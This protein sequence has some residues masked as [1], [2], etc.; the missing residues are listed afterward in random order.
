MA[1]YMIVGLPGDTYQD[2]IYY[3]KQ[4]IDMG[5]DPLSFNNAVPLHGTPLYDWV[6][7]QNNASTAKEIDWKHAYSDTEVAFSTPDF[8][9][10]ERLLARR[11]LIEYLEIKR[12]ERTPI[13]VRWLYALEKK[14]HRLFGI[15]RRLAKYLEHLVYPFAYP[16]TCTYGQDPDGLHA[17]VCVSDTVNKQRMGVNLSNLAVAKL[18]AVE[19]QTSKYPATSRLI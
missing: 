4:I 6:K 10:A 16:E 11:E 7:D 13:F 15:K 3:G 17:I 9:A 8:T 12:R 2:A 18:P 1:G 19:S 5:I 14:L